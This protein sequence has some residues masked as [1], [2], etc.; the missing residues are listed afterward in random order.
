MC[1]VLAE[2]TG[3]WH[4]GLVEQRNALESSLPNDSAQVFVT[5]PPYYDAVPYADLSD[6]FYVWLRR[7]VQS[8]GKLEP[9][10]PK[11]RAGVLK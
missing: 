7:M 9:L 8:F 5:D 3:H 2:W 1:K 11:E 4:A 10:T 6:F